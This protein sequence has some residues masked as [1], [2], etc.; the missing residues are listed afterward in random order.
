M[1]DSLQLTIVYEE[2]D[3]GWIICSVPEVPGTMSQGRTRQEARANVI[4]ALQLML[5]PEPGARARRTSVRRSRAAHPDDRRMKR[6]NLERHLRDHGCRQIDE[7]AS[8]ARWATPTGKRRSTVPRHREIDYRLAVRSASSLAYH[9]LR[10]H[11][12]AGLT[13]PG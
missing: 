3:D 12:D 8:H 6:R 2:G 10:G 13:A 1:S 7:G 4:D 5:S 9:R 11:A